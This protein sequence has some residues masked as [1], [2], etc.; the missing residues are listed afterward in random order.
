MVRVG[1][2]WGGCSGIYIVLLICTLL[3]RVKPFVSFSPSPILCHNIV[4]LPI[5]LKFHN[6]FLLS[7]TGVFCVVHPHTA[8]QSHSPLTITLWAST[9]TST[10]LMFDVSD[11]TH[12]VLGGVWLSHFYDTRLGQAIHSP[13][14]L[15]IHIYIVCHA[16]EVILFYY[17]I[18]YE[19]NI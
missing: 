17:F 16:F 10:I 14:Y 15:A 11:S 1:I 8:L 19:S 5:I 3:W 7:C 12:V 18:W 6:N 2:F 9:Y 13:L 4:I